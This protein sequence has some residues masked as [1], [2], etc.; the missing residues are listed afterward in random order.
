[1]KITSHA[2]QAVK[3]YEYIFLMILVG[4][5]I[6]SVLLP[7]PIKLWAFYVGY[8]KT[9]ARKCLYISIVRSKLLYFST[10]WK[11]YLSSD[12]DLV[13]KV[14]RRAAKYIL[15]DYMSGYKQ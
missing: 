7:N 14:Q 6:I 15:Q 13:E 10:L 4:G 5:S 11:P 1:M 12:I 9:T 3:I 2:P 8:L